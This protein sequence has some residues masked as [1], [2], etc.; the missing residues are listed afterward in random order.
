MNDSLQTMM[1]TINRMAQTRRCRA[2]RSR[3]CTSPRHRTW[4]NPTRGY[5][6][7]LGEGISRDPIGERGGRNLYGFV[8]NNPIS[9]IDALGKR[10]IT[11]TD[12]MN[13]RTV[14]N[15]FLNGGG[16]NV[17]YFWPPHSL[18]ERIQSHSSLTFLLDW[19]NNGAQT[20]CIGNPGGKLSQQVTFYYTAP[21]SQFIDDYLDWW[22][23]QGEGLPYRDYGLNVMGSFRV[24]AKTEIDCCKP[25]RSL[26]VQVYNRFRETSLFRKPWNRDE[27]FDLTLG[28]SPVDLYITFEKSGPF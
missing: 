7:A 6:C 19:Y 14:V 2:H 22:G 9:T 16:P 13:L 12:D 8:G 11:A 18:T 21:G 3:C 26:W 23:Q 20:F 25:W 24:T 10:G 28:L 5:E 15:D 4:R 1:T 17:Y 27:S